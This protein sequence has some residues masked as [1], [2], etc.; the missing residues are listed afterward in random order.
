MI[1]QRQNRSEFERDQ[2][3][4]LFKRVARPQIDIRVSPRKL[5][6]EP[7][8]PALYWA[9]ARRTSSR[10]STAFARTEASGSF[11]GAG[12]DSASFQTTVFPTSAAAETPIAAAN[13]ARAEM[14]CP[15][16]CFSVAGIC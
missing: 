14:I 15:C 11:A 2:V 10:F 1:P 3:R 5:E 9:S 7:R 13:E 6:L 4:P 12:R 16:A 8:L